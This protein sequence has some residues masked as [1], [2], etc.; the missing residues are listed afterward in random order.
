MDTFRA[1]IKNGLASGAPI[2]EPSTPD[3]PTPPTDPACEVYTVIK[4]DTLWRIATNKLGKGARYP[5]IMTLNGLTSDLIFA[6]Q[7]LMVPMK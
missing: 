3:H 7:Q 4:G 6:G 5:E 1:A 2:P